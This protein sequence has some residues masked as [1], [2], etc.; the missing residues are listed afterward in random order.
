MS[1]RDTEFIFE[2]GALKFVKRSWQQFFS[3]PVQ[4]VS[5]HTFR[6]MWLALLISRMEFF[7]RNKKCNIS[8]EKIMK[9]VL[10]HDI[11]ES[12]MGD[13]NLVSRR[14]CKQDEQ[15]AMNDILDKTQFKKDF[16][17]IYK[18]FNER[19]SWEAKI[20]KD[21]DNLDVDIECEE[22]KSRGAEIPKEWTKF[23][24]KVCQDFYTQSA[25][26]LSKKVKQADPNDW[27]QFGRNRFNSGD[28]KK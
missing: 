16:L 6:I 10:V 18:E 5:E 20:V 24:K 21:A 1:K 13:T 26:L 2:T 27:H 11:A 15:L 19:K 9:M 14:Y 23:R 12:R 17:S 25:R 3:I 7:G 22:L 28:W 4:N 8:E